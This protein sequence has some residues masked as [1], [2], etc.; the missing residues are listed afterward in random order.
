MK[1]DNENEKAEMEVNNA[2]FTIPLPIST[3][4]ISEP[5]TIASAVAEPTV[6]FNAF[7]KPLKSPHRRFNRTTPVRPQVKK[8]SMKGKLLVSNIIVVV[9][10]D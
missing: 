4:P 10:F 9:S 5:E 8:M 7:A 6:K 3:M 2:T 1:V